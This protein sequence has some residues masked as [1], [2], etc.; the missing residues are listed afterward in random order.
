MYIE[1]LCRPSEASTWYCV[2]PGG[3]PPQDWQSSPCAG[4]ELD[5]NSGL[6]ICSQVC[7]HWATSPPKSHL[8]SSSTSG[9]R[10]WVLV[11][12]YCVTSS[13]SRI[14]ISWDTAITHKGGVPLFLFLCIACSWDQV[15]SWIWML[16]YLSLLFRIELEMNFLWFWKWGMEDI[17]TG[18][19]CLFV[20]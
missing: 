17:E 9:A 18:T 2:I 7:Y 20:G 12:R 4:E 5:L 14:H 15:S 8:S 1:Y 10:S 13:P 6:L 16:C 3:Y 11:F 19:Y